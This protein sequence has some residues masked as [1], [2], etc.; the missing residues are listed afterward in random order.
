MS[1][2]NYDDP[3][4]RKQKALE[5][6]DALNSALYYVKGIN[7]D[8]IPTESVYAAF[9]QPLHE[10]TLNFP[11]REYINTSLV[12]AQIDGFKNMPLED[13]LAGSEKIEDRD[14]CSDFKYDI[15]NIKDNLFK[16]KENLK[17]A[18]LIVD[19]I[20]KIAKNINNDIKR[21]KNITQEI[22]KSFKKLVTGYTTLSCD[23]SEKNKLFDF[24]TTAERINIDYE[25]KMTREFT[26]ET[27]TSLVNK[28]TEYADS[29][30]NK[31]KTVSDTIDRIS[32][33][34]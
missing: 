13:A 11:D 34:I 31:I 28:I 26:V 6:I 24:I 22:L 32:G 19:E 20:R 16:E 17:P 33:E 1:L 10:Y 5:R 4:I 9:I 29:A 30:E 27:V 18:I 2:G 23:F 3:E 14:L 12:G 7:G 15:K 21:Y 8:M 25:M